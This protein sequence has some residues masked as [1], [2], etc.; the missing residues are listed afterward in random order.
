MHLP[1]VSLECPDAEYEMKDFMSLKA[2][3][4]QHSLLVK[5]ENKED[6]ENHTGLLNTAYVTEMQHILRTHINGKNNVYFFSEPVYINGYLVY[7][8]L[9]L[10]RQLLSTFY[11]LTKNTLS[12]GQQISRSFLESIIKVY[13]DSAADALK[14]KPQS[15]FNV[16]AK[17]R[18]ELVSKAGHDFLTTISLAGQ[19]SSG[20]HVLFDACNTISLFE[21]RG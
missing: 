13:L 20:L 2:L 10:S 14:S 9:E 12:N 16:L 5:Q 18:D 3:S 11:Y 7:V 15:D 21:I 8:V 1:F 17:S 4:I 6:K 19:N